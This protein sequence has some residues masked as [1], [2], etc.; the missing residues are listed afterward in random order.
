M[1]RHYNDSDDEEEAEA[2]QHTQTSSVLSSVLP[3]NVLQSHENFLRNTDYNSCLQALT[4]Q[5]R[6]QNMQS[7]LVTAPVLL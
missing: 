5:T 6:T 4:T 2:V 3:Q 7:L 1:A